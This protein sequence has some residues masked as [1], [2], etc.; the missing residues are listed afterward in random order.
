MTSSEVG[1]QNLL[2][3]AKGTYRVRR[4]AQIRLVL[5]DILGRGTVGGGMDCL[6]A[7]DYIVDLVGRTACSS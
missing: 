5:R 1:G 7:S 2:M 4:R 6:R 3:S